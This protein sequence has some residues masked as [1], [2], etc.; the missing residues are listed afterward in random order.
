MS[1]TVFARQLAARTSQAVSS[2]SE[3][4]SASGIIEEAEQH[5]S[6]TG[7]SVIIA[8]IATGVG[9]LVTI[10]LFSLIRERYPL[11]YAPRTKAYRVFLTEAEKET[12]SNKREKSD[13]SGKSNKSDEKVYDDDMASKGVFVPLAP[14]APTGFVSWLKPTWDD[15]I[16]EFKFLS[17][18][19]VEKRDFAL[20]RMLGLDAVTFL[21]YLRLLRWLFTCISL[22]VAVPLSV[23]NYYINTD[24]QYGSVNS[25]ASDTLNST[26]RIENMEVYTAANITG[27]IWY[28]HIMF[29]C[30]ITGLVWVFV[31]L[32]SEHHKVLV[33]EWAE[34]NHNEIAFKT[35][36]VTNLDFPSHEHVSTGKDDKKE[37]RQLSLRAV[38]NTVRRKIGLDPKTDANVEITRENMSQIA[39]HIKEFEDDLFVKFDRSFTPYLRAGGR[40]QHYDN[41]WKKMIGT[42]SV[43]GVKGRCDWADGFGTVAQ[44]PKEHIRTAV[45]KKHYI[46]KIQTKARGIPS[47]GKQADAPVN[48]SS[49]F[50]TLGS[51]REA[52]R[53]VEKF[54]ARWGKGKLGKLNVQRTK[55][56][57]KWVW[58]SSTDVRQLWENLEMDAK[59]RR[60]KRTIGRIV[61]Y[62][63]CFVNTLPVMAIT[64]LANINS[65]VEAV[66]WL[67]NLS[68]SSI[69][70][71]YTFEAI[72][73]I[74]PAS[75]S[76][77]F[78]YFLPILMRYLG[79]KSG[80]FTRG[81]LD[82]DV[83]KQL[84]FF[85]LVSN[86][87]VF[88][89]LGVLYTSYLDIADQ[90]GKGKENWNAIRQ[91]LGNVPTKIA[92]TYIEESSYWLS[93]YP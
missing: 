63:I 40:S 77:A 51:V 13:K 57:R 1:T 61:L 44:D 75:I 74:L 25:T 16:M 12:Q 81:Q 70:W 85:L 15:F 31:H 5:W 93:W 45:A 37:K 20:L 27:E 43:G 58:T 83:I 92:E 59:A 79:K 76:A 35:I 87:V 23:A 48:I 7:R 71:K 11:I 91:A 64:V 17:R 28:V 46:E 4:L 30:F 39:K 42:V 84:F 41:E 82:K 9:G 8:W 88:S 49:A 67:N 34:L 50:V 18:S 19:E 36:M 55:E 66:P 38:Q 22:V 26:E 53:V 62:V 52:H 10:C 6:V 14:Q 3:G 69:F 47:D 72:A 60:T 89:L 54:H 78:S 73:G 33:R 56:S 24:T 21:Q 86:F 80:A 90:I 32:H 2:T 29:E 65:A 68:K